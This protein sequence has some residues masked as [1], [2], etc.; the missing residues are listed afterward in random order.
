MLL[1]RTSQ[2]PTTAVPASVLNTLEGSKK[3]PDT[4]TFTRFNS[5]LNLQHHKVSD[6]AFNSDLVEPLNHNKKIRNVVGLSNL[7]T[8]RGDMETFRQLEHGGASG[9]GGLLIVE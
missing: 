1:Y 3:M 7:V 6:Y 9:A 4:A 2:I 5:N 8:G